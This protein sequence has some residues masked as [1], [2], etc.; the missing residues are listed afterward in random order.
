MLCFLV[1]FGTLGYGVPGQVLIPD[2]YLSL[3]FASLGQTAPVKTDTLCSVLDH[4]RANNYNCDFKMF[5][6]KEKFNV[7]HKNGMYF[8]S[9]FMKPAL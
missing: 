2:I 5:K 4:K 7:C 6:T 1:L 8:V 9:P 3:Y